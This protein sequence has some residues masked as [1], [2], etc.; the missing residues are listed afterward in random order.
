[1][2]RTEV[3]PVLRESVRNAVVGVCDTVLYCLTDDTG[4][5]P[6]SDDNSKIIKL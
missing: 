3:Q 6:V 2:E 4:H 1:M 5:V